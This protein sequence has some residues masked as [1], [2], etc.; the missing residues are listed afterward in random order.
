MEHIGWPDRSEV[1]GAYRQRCA[2][3]DGCQNRTR[4]TDP[5]A[6]YD[7]EKAAENAAFSFYRWKL[8][9]LY[10]IRVGILLEICTKCIFT[11]VR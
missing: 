11:L 5:L 9:I 10:K 6:Q 2:K 3:I 8:C 4:L 1:A 7:M